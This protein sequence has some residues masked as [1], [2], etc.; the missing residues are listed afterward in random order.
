M[1]KL[2]MIHAARDLNE[3]RVPPSNHLEAL[4]GDQKGQYSIRVNKQWRICFR[5][6]EGNACEVEI[7]DY[8]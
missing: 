6:F 7:I 5:W 4:K 2:W 3:L 8:H 1:R